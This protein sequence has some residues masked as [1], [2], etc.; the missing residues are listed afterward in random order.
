[1]AYNQFKSALFK[2]RY[3][4]ISYKLNF[5]FNSNLFKITRR[6]YKLDNVEYKDNVV[7]KG[8]RSGCCYNKFIFDKMMIKTSHGTTYTYF[9]ELHN[10]DGPAY[11]SVYKS[12]QRYYHYGNA[13]MYKPYFISYFKNGL[14]EQ[15]KYRFDNYEYDIKYDMKGHIIS[16]MYFNRY[17]FENG[18]KLVYPTKDFED[19]KYSKLLN[20]EDGP[21]HIKYKDGKIES[22]EYYKDGFKHRIDKPAV[23]IY[24]N[25]KVVQEEYYEKGLLHRIDK[26]AFIKYYNNGNVQVEVY[27]RHGKHYNK[28]GPYY[29]KYSKE[30]EIIKSIN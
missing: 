9:N 28:K 13:R 14:I 4:C 17:I 11:L 1:M 8:K 23:I 2:E 15:E 20:K 25:N 27:H 12:I 30:G 26:P 24:N 3:Y 5:I 19:R 6:E 22:V 10:L 7:K 21:A 16:E 18:L 29:V